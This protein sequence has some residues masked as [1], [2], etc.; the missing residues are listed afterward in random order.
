MQRTHPRLMLSTALVFCTLLAGCSDDSTSP[1]AT[2][3]DFSGN[4]SF[5]TE[6][7]AKA[8]CDRELG[9]EDT[10]VFPITQ[11]GSSASI[12]IDSVILVSLSVDGAKASGSA[13]GDGFTLAVVLELIDGT[14]AGTFTI[15]REEADCTEVM[16]VTGTRIN[17]AP[18]PAF[19]GN[20]D[21]D[22]EV[23][24]SNCEGELVGESEELC[25][26][27]TVNGSTVT[28]LDD[29][30]PIVGVGDG[31]SAV[32]HRI[33]EDERLRVTLTLAEG[34]LSGEIQSVDFVEE[35][36]STQSVFGTAREGS[37]PP[38]PTPEALVGSWY[39]D[40]VEYS[41]TLCID[42]SPEGLVGPCMTVSANGSTL[43]VDDGTGLG[44]LTGTFTDDGVELSRTEDDGTYTLHLTLEGD[45]LVGTGSKITT[46]GECTGAT[47][48]LRFEGTRLALP[49]SQAGGAWAGSWTL[50][51][52]VTTNGCDLDVVDALCT[53]FFQ[54]GDQV[55]L[56]DQGIQ[57]TVSGN[58][59]TASQQF[60][61]PDLGTRFATELVLTIDG[62]GTSLEGT[63]MLQ[64]T[65]LENPSETCITMA[66]IV[67]TATEECVRE[68]PAGSGP[69]M[70]GLG[71]AA[72][73]RP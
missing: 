21:L 73:E 24:D 40:V 69:R 60:D 16:S 14:C 61:V 18:S 8:L 4:W 53:T 51:F 35:C 44:L 7:V 45:Q 72:L 9:T 33:T 56:I 42:I 15:T 67:G 55:F 20:W 28:V 63:Q 26:Q 58:T 70:L 17:S 19:A 25:R 46:S 43:T 27:I 22:V 3:S 37:C 59:L 10:Y 2:P 47:L 29:E 50:D 49:C 12:L 64:L 32:L 23:L 39:A 36:S 65:S 11:N 13:T 38:P 66:D 52:D 48:D 41:S 6:I 57:G 1:G 68:Q 30:G 5:D 31:N 34:V 62:A 71:S 54:S